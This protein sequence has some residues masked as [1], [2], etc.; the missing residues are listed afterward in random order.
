MITVDHSN[1]YILN[2]LH[3]NVQIVKQQCHITA[4][5]CFYRLII[6]EPSCHN[7]V[8]ARQHHVSGTVYLTSYDPAVVKGKR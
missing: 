1:L 3:T 6:S 8:S 7:V 5:N 2:I 4:Y